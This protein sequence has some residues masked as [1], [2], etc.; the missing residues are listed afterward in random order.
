MIVNLSPHPEGPE[1]AA[2]ERACRRLCIAYAHLVD[3]RK[4]DAVQFLFTEDGTCELPGA[5]MAGR[6]QINAFFTE[7]LGGS[8]KHFA[9]VSTN[10]S[11]DRIDATTASGTSYVTLYTAGAEDSTAMTFSGVSRYEDE[12]VLV[13][14]A[15]LFSSRHARAV[16]AP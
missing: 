15:W 3:A 14:G 8:G 16:A 1:V 4:F 6:E 7:R 2:V 12:Y 5:K 11:M 9:H 13:D 10:H